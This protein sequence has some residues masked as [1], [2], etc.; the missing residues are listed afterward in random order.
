MKYFLIGFYSFAISVASAA[1]I[2]GD[3]VNAPQRIGNSSIISITGSG[4]AGIGG[5]SGQVGGGSVDID[6]TRADKGSKTGALSNSA[7]TVGNLNVIATGNVTA[8]SIAIES[9][10]KTGAVSNAP[11]RTG[12]TSVYSGGISAK[13]D[14]GGVAASLESG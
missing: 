2:S 6:T 11:S 3:V 12:D 13:R 5:I 9:G 8:G 4:Q 7:K 14:I 10:A 1:D